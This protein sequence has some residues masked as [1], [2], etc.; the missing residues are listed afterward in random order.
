MELMGLNE[1]GRE[2]LISNVMRKDSIILQPEMKLKDVYQKMMTNGCSVGPVF[3]GVQLI[4]IFDRE[5]I[6]KPVMVNQTLEKR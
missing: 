6:D 5:N 2:A 4:G 1:L 3:E